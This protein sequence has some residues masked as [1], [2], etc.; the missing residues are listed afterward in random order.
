[1]ATDK[2]FLDSVPVGRIFLWLSNPRHPTLD[3]EAKVIGQLC[4]KE[5]I[6]QLA[7]DI[8]KH[9]LNPLERFAV[10]PVDKKSSGVAGA[11]Y[12]VT[13]G[14]RR[15]CAV[16]LLNDPELA[17][18]NLRKSFE[19]LA[20]DKA[21][22]TI[23]TVPVV[24]FDDEEDVRLWLDRIHNG[25]QGGIGRKSWN[26]EQKARHD[27]E[28]KNKGAQALLD[29]AEAGQMLT[30]D[31]R[32][33]KLT[34]VQRFLSNDVFRE[35]LG[36][37]Q[38]DVDD[39]G[40]TRPKPEFD[41]ILKRFIRDLVKKE[42]V[43]SRMNKAEIVAYAR[44]LAS[45]PGVSTARI[46]TE[47]LSAG[48]GTGKP[49]KTSQGKP[50]PPTKAKHIRY[51]QQILDALKVYGS[52]KLQSLYHSICSIDLDPHTPIVCVGV[53]SFFETL[54]ACAG[55]NSGT[56]F[57]SFLSK[58]KLGLLGVPSDQMSS[59]RSAMERIREYG[60]STKH[61]KISA[62]FNGDQLNNDMVALKDVILKCIG[63]AKP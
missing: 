53:W 62:T 6:Y 45:V 7:R 31:E 54:T 15:L 14:N 56:S 9:G 60:N 48:A 18:A 19:K 3:N 52:E 29:Y 44:P 28:N 35:S 32:T 41:I 27:G 51:E 58:S 20:N 21:S 1:M 61:H 13:E 2:K 50:K 30:A 55:R 34:T 11:N 47:S 24:A 4:A 26:A 38:T 12:Y 42:D 10:V 8:A 43:N 37:D 36:F 57:D 59:L 25:P 39:V 46:E 17:P 63:D 49:K 5:D 33:G 16:K 22:I 23:N 40:R